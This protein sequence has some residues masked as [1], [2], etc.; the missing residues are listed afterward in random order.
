VPYI[1]CSM[2]AAHACGCQGGSAFSAI[3]AVQLAFA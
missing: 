2:L 1:P 3:S